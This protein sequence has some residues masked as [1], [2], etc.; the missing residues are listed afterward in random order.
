MDWSDPNSWKDLELDWS[1][2]NSWEDIDGDGTGNVPDTSGE[3]EVTITLD[4]VPFL[5]KVV[6][7]D[8]VKFFTKGNKKIT[9]NKVIFA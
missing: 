5:E 7:D 9:L 3:T 8:N 1:D 2:P 4:V 6:I